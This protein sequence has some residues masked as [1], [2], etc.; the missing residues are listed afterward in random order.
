M[1]CD[2]C[3]KSGTL[4]KAEVEGARVNAC[5]NCAKHGKIFHEIRQ[6]TQKEKAKEEKKVREIL[7]RKESAKTP[8]IT[9]LIVKDYSSRIKNAREKKGLKQEDFAKKISEK[10]SLLHQLESGHMQPSIELAK[11]LEHALGIKLI[12]EYRE[13]P[14]E[15]KGEKP[16]ANGPLTIGD[17][18]NVRKR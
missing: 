12:E 17:M 14:D 4:Y 18:I 16:R 2:L 8:E 3:G 5:E 1:N 9:L 15:L 13:D 10:E 6:V 11:K 7:Q